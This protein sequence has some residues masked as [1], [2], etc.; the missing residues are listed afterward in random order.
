MAHRLRNPALA[1]K[2]KRWHWA[3]SN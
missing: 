2:R 1:G 3:K